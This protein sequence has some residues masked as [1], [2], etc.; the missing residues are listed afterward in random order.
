MTAINFKKIPSISLVQKILAN[1]VKG[2]N[3]QTFIGKGLPISAE[4]F[5]E[6]IP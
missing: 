6:R 2:Q 1:E 5:P 4:E 3:L